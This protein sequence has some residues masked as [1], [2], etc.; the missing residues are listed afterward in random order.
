MNMKRYG[1]LPILLG[2]LTV[3]LAPSEGICDKTTRYTL[4]NGMVVILAPDHSTPAVSMNIW[5]NVG[6]FNELESESGMSHFIEHLLFDGSKG[7]K[8]GEAGGI[9]EASGGDFNAYTDYDNT[10]L[11]ATVASRNVE[12][13]IR[14]V[15]DTAL[16]PVFDP[17]EVNRERQVIL[18]EIR[19]D[20]D[21]PRDRLSDLLFEKAFPDHPY[22][23]PVIGTME[24]V[25]SYTR[26]DLYRYYS[27][28][29]RP[30]NM[31]AVLVGD[32]KPAD[33][34][35]MIERYL[36]GARASGKLRT[37]SVPY[38]L[39]EGTTIAGISKPVHTAYLYI[40]F[41]TIPITNKDLYP[42]DVSS[43]IL[44]SGRDS[45]LYRAVVDKGLAYSISS[46]SYTP[47]EAGLFL[48]TATLDPSEIIPTLKTVIREVSR[49][50]TDPATDDE[51]LKAET[52]T[53][54]DFVFDKET[55]D[56]RA[57]ALGFYETATDSIDFEKRYLEGIGAVKARD[58][59]KAAK[60]YFT[61]ANM[62][63]TYLVPS[64]ETPVVTDDQIKA[65]ALEAFAEPAV[66]TETMPELVP[67]PMGYKAVLANGI[68][69][70]I[71]ENHSLPVVS[72][73]G[74]FDGGLRYETPKD[75][76]ISNLAAKML[77][78]GTSKLTAQAIAE[79]T[80]RIAAD[81]SG[82]SGRD[83]IGLKAEFL[84]KYQ[85]EGWA[86]V[87]ELLTDPSF[88]SDELVK[89]KEIVASAIDQ[90]KD[91]LPQLTFDLFKKTLYGSYPYALPTL[92]TKASMESVS[93]A[94]LIKYYSSVAVPRH[95]VIS[96]VGDVVPEDVLKRVVDLFGG[97][98]GP[99][100]AA[101][102]VGTP[103]GPA[104]PIRSTE[105]VT[106]KEQ[107]HIFYGFLGAD[108]LSDDYYSLEVL[109]AALSGMGGRLF[110]ELREK[111]GLAYSVDALNVGGVG[112]GFFGVYMATAP[113]TLAVSIEGIKKELTL[114]RDDG[115][116][117][118]ELDRAKS[119]LIGNFELSL[120]K[121]LDAASLMASDELYGLGY[122]FSLR[123]PEK[124]DAVTIT[125]VKHAA[126]KYL[127]QGHSVLSVVTPTF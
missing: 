69:L 120:Q 10:V 72:V 7:L 36:G 102:A 13:M 112:R 35:P 73:V 17:K 103:A 113:K 50:A 8:P 41:N 28:H 96:V 23:K 125:D 124:I 108:Y 127:D 80:D 19:K 82:F 53:T 62:T 16:N 5:V 105:R 70:V 68:R 60:K 58:I 40:A 98:T 121:N 39:D 104:R 52:G 54:A 34:K 66:T 44:G 93:R 27:E 123:Y 1:G 85:D 65:A 14:V 63:V 92:G 26:D 119:Y 101:P 67:G 81:V 9:I 90:N 99:P 100:G 48:I 20:L 91:N 95:M 3:F 42:L 59:E 122:D 15:S 51:L 24:K 83:S 4:D 46:Y 64:S 97:L 21:S 78:R 106:D 79:R 25:G 110:M 126:E 118:E 12:T 45:R 2:L 88:D 74:A 57:R 71:K 117:Q 114:V 47:K 84:S 6:A 109:T 32:F 116:T 29:Y 22:G 11:T 75:N 87:A 56:N 30:D 111:Q 94:D 77:T 107:S 43:F 18:E 61:P 37:L 115:V 33:V 76:G 55:Y 38:P 49:L 31:V 86:I 89:V